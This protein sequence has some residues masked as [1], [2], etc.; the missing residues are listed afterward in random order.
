MSIHN[1][2]PV[3]RTWFERRFKQISDPQAAGWPVI[4][5]G[6]H[7]LIAAPTGSGKTLTAFLA[8]ID[9][10]VQ[11]SLRGEL[12][13]NETRVVYVS[14]LR[15]LSNDMQKN[16]TAP[17]IEMA[18]VAEEL[19][20]S[21]PTLH[22]GLRTGDTIARERVQLL[23]KPPHILVT[24]PESLY[25]LLTTEKGRGTLE[26]VD[27]LI[28]DE[29]HAV[30]RDKR[31]SHLSLT[32][33]RLQR[34]SQRAIQR[35]GLSATQKP[36][37]RVARYL[38]GN[39][40]NLTPLAF[41]TQK[42]TE[43]VVPIRA[44]KKVAAGKAKS[45]SAATLFPDFMETVES[46][47]IFDQKNSPAT[48]INVGHQRQ[49]DLGI[50]GPTS[51]LSA[52]CSHEQWGE[53]NEQLVELIQ[54]HR[55]TLIF[56][57][58]RRMAERVAHQLTPLL[59]ENMISSHHGSL[60]SDIRLSTEQRLKNGEIKAVVATAS[61]ELGIDVGYID[62][63][64]QVG[65]PRAISTFLQRIGRSGHALG[66]LPKGRLIAL[67]RDELI[68][69]MAL[70]Q[71]VRKGELDKVIVPENPLDILAQQ[72]VAEVSAEECS[73]EDLQK[74]VMS[75]DSFRDLT[76][77]D[78]DEVIA[79]LSEGI[80]T[81]AGRSRVYLHHDQINGRIRARKG[82]RL[83]A[84]NNAGAI[85]DL[86]NY[87]VV[88]DGEETV[89]GSVDEDF[90]VES[91]A[92][93][94]FL[95][96]SNAWRIQGLR[97]NDLMVHDA[98][99]SP[100]SIPFWRGEAPGRTFELSREVSILRE[101]FVERLTAPDYQRE[102]FIQELMRDTAVSM[103]LAAQAVDYLQAQL[104]AVG[105]VPHQQQILFERFFD[106]T[107][108]MQVVVHAPFGGRITRA[109]GLAMRKRFCRSFDFE[110][111][112]TADDDGFILA[113]GPQHSFPLE[114]LF[115]MMTSRNVKTLLEQAVL[116][117]PTFQ[118]RWRWNVANSLI[119]HRRKNGQRIPPPLQRFRSDDLLTAVFP[120]LT[121]CQE[122]ITGDHE[123]P[124]HPLIRQTM[125]D[126]L[127]EAF[128]LPELI[129][130]LER[131][132]SGE[133]KM[134]ARDTREPSPFSY[135]LLNSNPYAFLDGNNEVFE[136]R[137]R[138]APTRREV[139]PEKFDDLTVLDPVAIQAV[140]AEIVPLVREADELHDL[141]LTRFIMTEEEATIYTSFMKVLVREGRATLITTPDQMKFW[142]CT[143]RLSAV[144]SLYPELT[145]QP[146]VK[147]PAA[148]DKSWDV[149][150]VRQS[151]LRGL[152]DESGPI[153]AQEIVNRFHWDFSTIFSTLESLEGE[154]IVIRGWFR[155][156]PERDP[157]T[158]AIVSTR[159]APPPSDHD[160]DSCDDDSVSCHVDRD[161]FS[162]RSGDFLGGEHDIEWCHRRLL[163]RIHR[164]SL[165]D[166][167]RQVQAVDVATYHRFLARHQGL[168]DVLPADEQRT[169]SNGVL[170]SVLQLQGMELPAVSW[171]REVLSRRIKD[172]QTDWIDEL[173]FTG[174]MCWG[175][176]SPPAGKT[177]QSRPM[178][179]MSRHA[180]LALI[181]RE[182]LH[183]I[184]ARTPEVT[185]VGLST[186]A[187]D[188]LGL[189]KQQGAMFSSDLQRHLKVLP[190][191]LVEIMG[192]LVSRGFATA[193]GFAGLRGLIG[194]PQEPVFELGNGQPPKHD[195]NNDRP[196]RISGSTGRWGLWCPERHMTDP[197][198]EPVP[199]TYSREETREIV[200]HWA[201]LLVRRWGVIY[202]DLLEKESS[203]PA[204]SE[205]VQV[206]RTFEARGELRGG[207]FI[208]GVAGEQYCL[209][210]RLQLLNQLK[211]TPGES[212]IL[213]VSAADPLNLVGVI[214]KSPRI[215]I[216]ANHLVTYRAG[217]PVAW[218]N[219]KDLQWLQDLDH[220]TQHAIILKHHQ[221][222]VYPSL[223]ERVVQ[224]Q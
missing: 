213:I 198:A 161:Y 174:E 100:P 167:R 223:T 7:T 195:R 6:G 208:K 191:Q 104:N 27:T 44:R 124:D 141:L 49:L 193:D 107:G 86:G 116:A 214:D 67:T 96:G 220:E 24:T 110:L 160:H 28:V 40:R 215:T 131:V 120:R 133:I 199:R 114:S 14:P 192:E 186:P 66:L 142:V 189:L 23:K 58:T 45:N 88:V 65:S 29:I 76:T 37:E 222:G 15:A 73:T 129:R 4:Q 210:D 196:R 8:V 212:E 83:A 61:L 159:Y 20:V 194:G 93:D 156:Q 90:A 32:M 46:P 171:E 125:K 204:W 10:L 121:G 187:Q 122:N 31:G 84:I 35:I 87:R 18:A 98:Q 105:V 165:Q 74:L 148:L 22:V 115:S 205:L 175:R 153:S 82:A 75:A 16:L 91:Q 150:E 155:K 11:E 128:D 127:Y 151:I 184:I 57:N 179:S 176:L 149:I 78:F 51:P 181:M 108:G 134:V 52:V 1:F 154:G 202:R 123:L 99:G 64:L 60:A 209:P 211:Q 81:T 218:W 162:G 21:W 47:R 41:E 89:V 54:S 5:Q 106:A 183:W 13:G 144:R 190:A 185:V 109:W 135:E 126:C 197:E 219:N 63:V 95:L 143:E 112:A 71:A 19:N 137:A 3:I 157:V 25:L 34:V 206:Y 172:Y 48:I 118:L 163:A 203:A 145:C 200:E 216:Q 72:I 152:L 138:T 94:I 139:N 117:V 147:I 180:P 178:V 158:G 56:V 146:A 33:E 70:V 169:G 168:L 53:I 113:L 136:R 77:K 119:V 201:W 68:E 9:R 55:S 39:Q 2:H 207:R 217:H 79:M 50:I 97:G 132:E 26:Q 38:T 17:L 92:G 173:C 43:S 111:Q 59:G 182:D 69:S 164:R 170:Q 102:D 224:P 12:G 166:L 80:T 30:I 103:D 62:L 101:K 177:S 36:L 85:P 188:A 221:F 130:I 42:I 140:L